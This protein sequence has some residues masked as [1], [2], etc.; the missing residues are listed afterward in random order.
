MDVRASDD[1]SWGAHVDYDADLVERLDAAK[2][3]RVH[4]PEVVVC[5]WPPPGNDF[6][7]RVFETPSVQTYVAVV[8][9]TEADAG[10]WTSYRS[11][12]AFEM[13]VHRRLGRRVLPV[14]RS[15]V[16]VFERT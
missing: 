5:S 4:R 16:L 7:R 14:G 1:F 11:Q 10:D 3:L 15:R 2:A 6:E 8:S 13:T 12:E 9:P